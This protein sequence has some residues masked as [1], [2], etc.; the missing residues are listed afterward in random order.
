MRYGTYVFYN[1][2]TDDVYTLTDEE[3]TIVVKIEKGKYIVGNLMSDTDIEMSSISEKI[4]T[5]KAGTSQKFDEIN[6]LI[7]TIPV[8]YGRKN[9]ID[10]AMHVVDDI[11][12]MKKRYIKF[13]KL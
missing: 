12:I 4:G 7:L 9:I 6:G 13:Y 2:Q 11:S 3:F 5:L 1:Y 8:C 10:D